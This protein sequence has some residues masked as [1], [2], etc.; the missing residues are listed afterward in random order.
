[1]VTPSCSKVTLLDVH[2]KYIPFGYLPERLFKVN[3]DGT[4]FAE[5]VRV[6]LEKYFRTRK[7]F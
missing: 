2:K 3:D 4:L 5:R 1:M 6:E 7:D